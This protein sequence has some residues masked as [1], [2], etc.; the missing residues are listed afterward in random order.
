METIQTVADILYQLTVDILNIHYI[1]L[2]LHIS[3][4][5]VRI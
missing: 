1:F 3:H 4:C 5:Y 2:P